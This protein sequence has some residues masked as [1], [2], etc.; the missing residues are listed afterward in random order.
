MRLLDTACV[1]GL[2]L[3]CGGRAN[4][5]VS[6]QVPVSAGGGGL[7]DGG[8]GEVPE[9]AEAGSGPAVSLQAGTCVSSSSDTLSGNIDGVPTRLDLS[10]S[11]SADGFPDRQA[12]WSDLRASSPDAALW[13]WGTG[14]P[15]GRPQQ[16]AGALIEVPKAGMGSSFYCAASVAASSSPANI[17]RGISVLLTELSVLGECPGTRVSGEVDVCLGGSAGADCT[18]DFSATGTVDGSEVRFRDLGGTLSYGS[19]GGAFEAS[20]VGDGGDGGLILFANASDGK[21]KGWLRLPDNAPSNA[22]SVF[23]LSSAFVVADPQGGYSVAFQS[24]GRLGPCPGTPVGGELGY[25]DRL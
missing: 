5:D 13:V 7:G 21:L 25:C 20:V 11:R 16:S 1:V 3:A 12:S 22:G 15:D 8:R 9:T 17:G 23:C 24:V 4:H 18:K 19:V 14:G 10:G 6:G 2:V